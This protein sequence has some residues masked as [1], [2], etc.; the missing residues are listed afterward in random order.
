M[1]A[2]GGSASKMAH[3]TNKGKLQVNITDEHRCKNI[4]QY[5]NK[6]NPTVH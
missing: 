3:S 5:T 6:P 4:Q 1:T 2:A